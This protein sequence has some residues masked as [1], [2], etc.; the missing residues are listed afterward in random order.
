MLFGTNGV[1]GKF[2]LLTPELTLKLS[3]AIG[4]YFKSGK[5]LVA[6]DG[7]ITGECL[8]HAVI[9]GLESAGCEVVDLDY[10]SAPTAEFMIKKLKADGLVIVTASH[11]PPE[12][13]ALKVVDGKGVTVSWERGEEIE[14]LMDGQTIEWNKVKPS[15]NYPDATKEHVEAILKLMDADS[16]KKR[17]PKIVLDCGNGM[18]ALIAPR[19]FA[20]LGCE[21]ILLNE[22]VDG[23]F[24]GRPSEPTEA[25]VG[26][27]I[28]AVKKHKAD[29]GIAW[30]GDGDRVIF[31]DET[32][33]FL[34]GDKVLALCESLKLRKGNILKAVVTTVATS[35]VVEDIA[36]K[37]GCNTI[38]TKIGAPYLSEEMLRTNAIIGGEEVG[39][40]IWP[41]LSLA[42]DGFLTGAKMAEMICERKLSEWV[43]DVPQYFNEKTK[44]ECDDEGKRR[45]VEGM[46]KYA[47]KK[48]L[49]V[50]S[51]DGVRINLAD[52]WVI[53]RA[54]GTEHYVRVFAEAKTKQ[55]AKKLMEEYRKI[56][57]GFISK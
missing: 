38:Y 10:A 9:S 33:A 55:K 44:I 54:S 26:E 11:N 5:I 17:K 56:A 50:V 49:S 40:V 18:A 12:W 14:K 36:S 24:P 21:T 2:D 42:K 19:L 27:L 48:K 28:K 13:N 20:E 53:V 8:K 39:G 3:K 22:N 16:I 32:G 37:Y 57:E 6:R 25:N 35:K 46:R 43:S 29:G 52:S 34:V 45:I 51:V 41:E 30:D 4:L 47:E 23:T 7:R 31:I 1:R 15:V